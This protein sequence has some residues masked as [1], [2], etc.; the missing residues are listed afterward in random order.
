[1]RSFD[2]RYDNE[3]LSALDAN[4]NADSCTTQKTTK[5]ILQTCIGIAKS[6]GSSD[7]PGEFEVHFV[8]TDRHPALFINL[9]NYFRKGCSTRTVAVQ[10]LSLIKLG[11]KAHG[12]KRTPAFK[13]SFLQ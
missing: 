4:V 1:M 6:Q 10:D 12:G 13:W 7:L 3:V 11:S 5:E 2:F 8:L 9:Y